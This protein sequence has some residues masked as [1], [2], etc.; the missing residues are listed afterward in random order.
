MN[1]LIK[2]NICFILILFIT[3]CES[4]YLGGDRNT[5]WEKDL[6]YLSVALPKKHANLFFNTSEENFNMEIKAL[7][8][9][10]DNLKDEEVVDGIYK[11]IASLGDT[12]TTVYKESLSVYPIQFYFFNDGIYVI[13]TTSEYTESLYSKLVK[14]NGVDIE[15]VQKALLPLIAV[16]NE[17]M[18]KK[19]I[20][21]YLMNPEI[22][23]GV[24]IVPDT[25]KASFTFEN[26]KGEKF[27]LDIN[28]VNRKTFNGQFVISEYDSS[29]PLYMQDSK[30]NYWYKY[31]D[32][33]RTVYFKYNRCQSQEKNDIEAFTKE[34]LNFLD[35]HPID[36]FIIDIRDNTGG[37]DKYIKPFINWLKEKDINNKNR[38]FVIVGRY[39]FSS[40][41]INAVML[42]K[43]TNATF[44]GEATSGKPN[45]YGA[46]SSFELPNSK[47]S[48]QYSKQYNK[49]SEDDSNTFMPDKVIDISIKDYLSKKDPI[50][51]YILGL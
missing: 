36:K 34:L 29:Y 41:I 43:E 50:L 38:L 21:K 30:L 23:Y 28:S 39:T 35:S 44:I 12:H 33:E 25:Q 32:K 18:I 46:V 40:A 20:P 51:D 3:G 8:S 49:M 5:K 47:I 27:N 1:K 9:S 26:E 4:Q 31:L 15:Q 45:H 19:A 10:L 16:D 7:K 6:N 17:A 2:I 22:L 13:N 42:K 11:I 37:S 14:I 48:I 24:N